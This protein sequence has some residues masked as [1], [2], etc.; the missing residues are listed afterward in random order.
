M[1][2][3]FVPEVYRQRRLFKQQGNAAQMILKLG[4]NSLYGKL[5]QQIGYRKDDKPAYQQIEWAGWITSA[6]RAS[7]YRVAMQHPD[8]VV[9][10][11]TDGLFSTEPHKVDQGSELGQWEVQEHEAAIVAQSGVYWYKDANSEWVAK[12]RGFDPGSLSW[13]TVLS[14]WQSG[15]ALR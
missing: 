15:P 10:F 11:A 3:Q 5:A 12:Y 13:E 9:M 14:A 7:L 1:P 2:F 4:L 6:T 8:S